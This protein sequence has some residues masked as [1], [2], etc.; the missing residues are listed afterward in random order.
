MARVLRIALTALLLFVV[1][2]PAGL[3]AADYLESV[4][5]DLSGNVA[6]PTSL[7]TLGVGATT[8]SAT[9]GGGDF[10]LFSFI[11]GPGTRLNSI[12]LGSYNG[13][14][15][16][17]TA[18]E[19]GG[20]WT[21]GLGGAVNPAVLLGWTHISGG[22]VGTDILD[23]MG[24]ASPAIGFTPPLLA[25]TYTMEIQDTGGAVSGSFTLNVVPEPSTF[26]LAA[27]ALVGL[28]TSQLRRTRRQGCASR[29]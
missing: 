17:F 21:A 13:T 7:G 29:I 5:G 11:L 9:F 28:S 4:N 24:A 18:L 20:T 1:V 2:S 27:L 12:T 23:N 25:G 6:A 26:V 22:L 8:V 14:S 15:F 10:D 3:R 16:S 19:S